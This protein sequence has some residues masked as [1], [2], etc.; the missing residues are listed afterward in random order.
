MV[1][2]RRNAGFIIWIHGL[3]NAPEADSKSAFFICQI[4]NKNKLQTKNNI[5]QNQKLN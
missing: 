4:F 2:A 5:L 1:N 3:S